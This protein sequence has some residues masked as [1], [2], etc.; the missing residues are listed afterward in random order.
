MVDITFKSN[1]LRIAKAQAILKVSKK[2]TID[3]IVNKTVPKGDVFEMSKTAGLFA[4]KRTSDT[5]PQ[6]T[7]LAFAGRGKVGAALP[8]DGGDAEAVLQDFR[9]EGVDGEALAARL[10]RDGVAA[11]EA[12]WKALLGRI[13][14]KAAPTATTRSP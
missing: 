14:E 10:Q 13:W 5:I 6:Q 8:T 12:S 4:V 11:F 9:R 3:A 2:E 1:T 7:L